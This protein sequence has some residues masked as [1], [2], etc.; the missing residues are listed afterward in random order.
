MALL[1][2]RAMLPPLT[3][4]KNACSPTGRFG[5]LSSVIQY[6]KIELIVRCALLL[7]PHRFL[8]SKGSSGVYNVGTLIES[9]HP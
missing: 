2:T 8:F 6:S 9:T 4:S 5:D 7:P 3:N 1:Y